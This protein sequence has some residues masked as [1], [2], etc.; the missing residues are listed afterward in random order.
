MILKVA[1]LL[2]AQLLQLVAGGVIIILAQVMVVLEAEVVAMEVLAELGMKVGIHLLRVIR[3]RQE[4]VLEAVQAVVQQVLATL[5][6][7]M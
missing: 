1:I 6:H 7:R 3:E 2:L 4:A 5:P